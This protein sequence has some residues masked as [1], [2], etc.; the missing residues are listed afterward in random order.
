MRL[1]IVVRNLIGR[2]HTSPRLAAICG[3]ALLAILPSSARSQHEHHGGA[4]TTP[5]VG[6]PAISFDLK[7]IDGKPVGLAS[8]RGKPLVVNFFATWCDPCRE[9]MPLVNDLA[10]KGAEGGY[11][12]LGIAV[13][14]S[15]AAVTE[16]AREAKLVFPVALDLNSSVKRAYRIFGPPA[17]FFIDGE[18]IIRDVIFGPMTRQ[19]AWEA[20]KKLGA[21]S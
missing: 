12:V 5:S 19:R 3:V 7:S 2:R 14:D 9:E 20:L 21:P 6:R 18:G 11:N 15:R 13:E 1:C 17:T 4:G 16:Y 8:F 10:I